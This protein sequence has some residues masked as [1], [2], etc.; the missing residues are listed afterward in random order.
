MMVGQNGAKKD[1][2]Q[3]TSEDAR[4]YG[5]TDCYGAHHPFRL[6]CS[7]RVAWSWQ[8]DPD[9][10][11]EVRSLVRGLRDGIDMTASSQLL[12]REAPDQAPLLVRVLGRVPAEEDL[13][14]Q[15]DMA[16][17]TVVWAR[18]IVV[19]LVVSVL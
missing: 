8:P 12:D 19:Q 4:E 3:R 14:R 7:F 10:A 15:G 6:I 18:I 16:G 9:P 13:P 5:A 2:E 11:R 17:F 1:T